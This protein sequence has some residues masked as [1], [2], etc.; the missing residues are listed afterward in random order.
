MK[1]ILTAFALAL[2]FS[3]FAQNA[4]DTHYQAY[5]DDDRLSHVSISAKMFE[6]FTHI[7]GDTPEEK[8]ILEAISK[9][10]GM[11]MI[12]GPVDNPQSEYKKALAIPPAKYEEL[13][14]VKQDGEEFTF[15]IKEENGIISELLMVG[16]TQ[17]QEGD[18]GEFY[19]MSLF[20]EI[21][22]KQIRR[23]AKVIEID[24]MEHLDKI[25]SE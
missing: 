18:Q 20:G 17:G 11:K 25:D 21:D 5:A 12:A 22:L 13:M 9:L 19:I 4:V 8:E 2:S 14:V 15:K 7:E 16:W 6:L 3:V 23:L 24:G 10:K 1:T